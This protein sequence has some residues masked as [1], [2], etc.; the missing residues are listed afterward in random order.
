MTQKEFETRFGQEVTTESFDYANRVYMAAGDIDKD[1]FCEE[2]KNQH[3]RNSDIVTALTMEVE[4]L[5]EMFGAENSAM[6]RQD[7]KRRKA[8]DYLYEN[9]EI[10]DVEAKPPVAEA[11]SE[12]TAEEKPAEEKAE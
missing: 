10:P 7:I 3:L 6:L 9:A 8:I 11:K 1:K 5:K 2:W 12:E 4:K